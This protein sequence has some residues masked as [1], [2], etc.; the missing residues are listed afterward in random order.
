MDWQYT[1]WLN[2]KRMGLA[3]LQQ[4][5]NVIDTLY[6]IIEFEELMT[7]DLLGRVQQIL[8]YDSVHHKAV[9]ADCFL[10]VLKRFSESAVATYIQYFDFMID[11]R[12]D[13]LMTA[14]YYRKTTAIK[15]LV[16]TKR[17]NV[18]DTISCDFLSILT[19]K[20]T[21]LTALDVLFRPQSA[22]E[23]M[24]FDYGIFEYL[25]ARGATDINYQTYQNNV[26]FFKTKPY[27]NVIVDMSVEYIQ[28]TNI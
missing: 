7:P 24:A 13:F 14:V 15:Y 22:G 17:C 3:L 4:Q 12:I 20:N 16:E 11:P 9:I 2:Y 10:S 18:K 23:R 5:L 19:I 8:V 21:R 1:N 28:N 27:I 25:C 26:G 6:Q